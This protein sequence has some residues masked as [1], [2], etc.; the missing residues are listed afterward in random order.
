[1]NLLDLIL[2][3]AIC[4]LFNTIMLFDAI[5]EKEYGR[6]YIYV[7]IVGLQAFLL[8]NLSSY[9]L[10]TVRNEFILF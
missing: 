9:Y 1:M 10:E 2:T 3:A 5:K 7:F 8:L 6:L 4:L